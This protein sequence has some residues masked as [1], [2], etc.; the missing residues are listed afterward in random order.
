MK[1][2]QKSGLAIS[3][4][5]PEIVLI[6]DYSNLSVILVRDKIMRDA[7]TPNLKP[8]IM[9][10]NWPQ[11]LSTAELPLARFSPRTQEILRSLGIS[12][13]GAFLNTDWATA[14]LGTLDQCSRDELVDQHTAMGQTPEDWHSWLSARGDV[15]DLPLLWPGVV[16]SLV[17]RDNK[18][19]YEVLARR[20]RLDGRDWYS[21]DRLGLELGIS[22]E[23]VRQIESAALQ[24]LRTFLETGQFR[25]DDES[26]H[27][28]LQSE[29]TSLLQRLQNVGF[30]LADAE[31][32]DIL[33]EHY[34]KALTASQRQ[35]MVLLLEVLGLEPFHATPSDVVHALSVVWLDHAPDKPLLVAMANAAQRMLTATAMVIPLSDLLIKVNGALLPLGGETDP[36]ALR[37]LLSFC[38][39]VEEVGKDLYQ[40]R[41]DELA[42]IVLQIERIMREW[43]AQDKVRASTWEITQEFNRRLVLAGLPGNMSPHSACGAMGRCAALATIGKSGGWTLTENAMDTRPMFEIL[44][45]ALVMWNRPATPK[46]LAQYVAT[47]RGDSS[48]SIPSLLSQHSRFQRVARGFYGLSIWNLGEAPPLKRGEEYQQEF[49]STLRDIFRDNDMQPLRLAVLAGK[50]RQVLGWE[51]GEVRRRVENS[52][53]LDF[54]SIGKR[55]LLAHWRE[56]V[57]EEDAPK[58]Q[59]KRGQVQEAARRLLSAAPGGQMAGRALAVVIERET[60]FVRPVIYNTLASMNDVERRGEP[61]S[62]IY[63]LVT[64]ENSP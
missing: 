37:R 17:G 23:R 59:S 44:E 21:L 47:Q 31:L 64:P 43:A 8:H 39:D 3:I 41:F 22:R 4:A 62:L 27:P 52:P 25:G 46:E 53:W 34:G 5:N 2:Q 20:F 11:D 28:A 24:K 54:T 42:T 1:G 57:K 51:D 15:L 38:P 58:R 61:R 56:K 36:V 12:T 26:L 48:H 16:R 14:E 6:L 19:A 40:C 7:E 45:E 32:W 35:F 30:P 49:D 33:E 60:G 29:I 18:R 50:L 55:R 9:M 13:L 10:T 63:Q